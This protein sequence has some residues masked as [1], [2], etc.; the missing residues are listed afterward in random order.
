MHWKWGE[1]AVI[2][3]LARSDGTVTTAIPAIV[4]QDDSKLLALFIPKETPF[5]DNWVIPPAQRVASVDAIT[6]SAQRQHRDLVWRNDTIR[7]Y[8]VGF[9]Y[10]VW[11]NFDEN[12]EFASWY[13][14]LEA[15]FVRTGIGI[16][17]RDYALD[18]VA[19]PDGRWHWKDEAEFQRRLEV[20]IDTL[21]HQMRVRA[22]GQDFIQRF[23]RNAWPFNAGWQD[24]RIGSLAVCLKTGRG[25]SVNGRYLRRGGKTGLKC[26]SK[27]TAHAPVFSPRSPRPRSA[28]GRGGAERFPFVVI[29]YCR[30]IPSLPGDG[31][32]F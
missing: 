20:R 21:D 7:L 13:G 31:Q 24:W 29:G 28:T 25:F 18:I 30:A 4:M 22:A 16:D 32:I 23:E 14:N 15:P 6:P 3:N 5:K 9:G 10:S 1:T 17:T 11:L 27:Q 19:L 26:L 8:L 12:G 2:R